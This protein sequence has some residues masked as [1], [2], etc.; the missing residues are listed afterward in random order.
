MAWEGVAASELVRLVQPSPDVR[1]VLAIGRDGYTTNVPYESFARPD[2]IVADRMGGSPLPRE[3]GAP[4]RLVVPSLYAWKS[5]KYVEAIEF[6]RDL[7]RGFWE[8]RGYHDR[9]DPWLEERFREPGEVGPH[10]STSGRSATRARRA[11][12]ERR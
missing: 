1:W 9:G 6:H 11:G 10:A 8:E 5:A 3:H 12:R 2:T 4:L 7:V